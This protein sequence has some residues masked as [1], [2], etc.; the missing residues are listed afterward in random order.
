MNDLRRSNDL[1][2]RIGGDEF[3]LVITHLDS[4]ATA[5]QIAHRLRATFAKP[6]DVQGFPVSIK[7]SFGIAVLPDHAD[8]A[9][10]LLKRADESMYAAKRGD[11][12]VGIPEQRNGERAI[13]R[14]SLLGDVANALVANEFFLEYQPQISLVSG[15]VIGVEALV[16]WRHPVAGVLYPSEFIGL[17]EQT[18]LIG[19]ITEQVL[20]LALNQCA[21][22]RR[23]GHNLRMA[24][25]IS[26]RNLQDLH[27]PQRV[28][29]LLVESGVEPGDVDLEITENT[30]GV[31]SSTLHWILTKLRATGVSISIDDFGTGYSSM[32]Q[33]REL[34]VDRIKID[35][36]F[37]TNMA[38]QTRDALIVGAI[39]Q[40][41]LALGIQTVA[42]GV[43]DSDVAEMLLTLG[44]T[45]AQGWLYG[46]PASADSL[47]RVLADLLPPGPLHR[48]VL[49]ESRL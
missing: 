4:V 23:H 15:R 12:V 16:R 18:E 21:T 37:V 30:V 42:E 5:L 11:E 25:N 35:R 31:D 47:S 6:S 43:E 26:A 40:L 24:V 22:W 48:H 14:I 34:P 7:A 17:A 33:L 46:K 45:S 49:E 10:T 1:L 19:D 28:H 44:C 13:G 29:D 32:A 41:G 39:I 8:S 38:R 2:A 36:S 27:F 9:G 20:R 3:A